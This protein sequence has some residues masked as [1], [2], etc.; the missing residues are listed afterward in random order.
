MKPL[1]GRELLFLVLLFATVI[2]PNRWLHVIDLIVFLVFFFNWKM[3]Y[4]VMFKG[5]DPN[6]GEYKGGKK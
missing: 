4:A 1:S 3:I 6:L 5:W 2:W